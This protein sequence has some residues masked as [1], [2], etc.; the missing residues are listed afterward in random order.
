MSPIN[1][2]EILELLR[3]AGDSQ[4]SG[5]PV[6]QIEH[7]WQCG[8]LALQAGASA[9]LQLASWL[10][11]IGHLMVGWAGTPTLRGEDDEHEAQGARLLMRLWGGAVAEPVR[12]HVAAKRYLVTKS[13]AYLEKLSEDSL[14]SLQLQGGSMTPSQLCEYES[15][16]YARDALQLRS[17]DDQGK[18]SGWFAPSKGQA[19]LQLEELMRTV[20]SMPF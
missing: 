5:E 12:L 4:Y 3:S 16:A 6:S 15:N 17:W 18:V 9:P 1:P 10:H 13:P 7:A 19:L 11:D 2:R 8:Q 20:P 14:R